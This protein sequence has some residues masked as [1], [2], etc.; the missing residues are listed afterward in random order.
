MDQ[1]GAF[2]SLWEKKNLCMQTFRSQIMIS[3]IPAVT[4]SG[5]SIFFVCLLVLETQALPHSINLTQ[6]HLG[7]FL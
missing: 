1:D 3:H 5:V 4:C 7:Y 6:F 2:T